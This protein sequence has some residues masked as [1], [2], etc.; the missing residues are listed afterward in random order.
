MDPVLGRFISPDD[1]DPTLPG[2]GTNRYAYAA[3]DP[4]NKADP[5]GHSFWSD[6]KDFFSGLFGGGG[7]GGGSGG[8]GGGSGSGS[9]SG[10]DSKPNTQTPKPTLF[11]LTAGPIGRLLAL[12]E[13]KGCNAAGCIRRVNDSWANTP[14]EFSQMIPND[15]SHKI[16]LDE[17]K[18]SSIKGKQLID[19]KIIRFSQDSIKQTF[20]NGKS[21]FEIADD[22]RNGKINPKNIEPIRVV[23]I[24]GKLYSIDNRRL[25]AAKMAGSPINVRAATSAEI[26]EA[27]SRNKFTTNNYGGSV[28]IRGTGLRFPGTAG[29]GPY[30]RWRTR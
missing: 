25:A 28:N 4:V 22:L 8:S 10:S 5:N 16:K 30:S 12:A 20:G 11:S 26:S 15:P 13:K 6:V 23:E 14:D 1:W 27:I 19:S 21:I 7:G 2:V 3:N 29:W 18:K 9:G 24:N 17:I